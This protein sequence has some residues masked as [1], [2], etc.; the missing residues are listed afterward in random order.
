VK[1]VLLPNFDGKSEAATA[2]VL[3]PDDGHEVARNLLSC[4]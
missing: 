4:I 1:A 3:A 2:D